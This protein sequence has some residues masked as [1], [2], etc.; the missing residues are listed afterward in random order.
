VA[1]VF[2]QIFWKLVRKVFLM[3]SKSSSKLG[4]VPSK[5][6]SHILKIEEALVAAV[7]IQIFWILV[8][9]V[10]LMI[11]KVKLEDGFSTVKNKVTGAKNEK[12]C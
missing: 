11:S 3:I 1:A 9:K 5:N 12:A 8:R 6:R 4:H 7:L 2:V 10:V